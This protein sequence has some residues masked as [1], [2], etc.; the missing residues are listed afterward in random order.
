MRLLIQLNFLFLVS[1]TFGQA[2]SL[3]EKLQGYAVHDEMV[4]FIYD[5]VVYEVSPNNVSVTGAFRSWDTKM[6]NPSWQLKQNDDLWLLSIDNDDYKIIQPNTKFK[7]RTNEGEWMQPPT[8]AKN[9]S[10]GD[11]IF[12][13][14]TMNKSLKAELKDP[15]TIWAEVIGERPLDITDYKI[16]NAHGYE[17]PIASVLPNTATETLIKTAEEMDIKRVYF[18]EIPGMGLKAF[19]SFDGWFRELY[20]SKDFG[21]NVYEDHTSIRVFAPRATG[22]KLYFIK[23]RM[24]QKHT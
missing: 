14:T 2:Y 22:L 7:F 17:V 10:G 20:S 1:I 13:K 12:M 5:P 8:E 3:E 11:L 15:T 16:T 9:E 19:C 23:V 4:T 24:I 6:D 21:A 18:L